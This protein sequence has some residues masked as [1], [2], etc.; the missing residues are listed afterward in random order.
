MMPIGNMVVA[1]SR[2]PRGESG[3]DRLGDDR[4]LGLF[5][6]KGSSAAFEALVKRHGPRVLGV[7]RQILR[8]HHDAEDAFQATFLLLA[9]KAGTIRKGDSVGHWLHGVAHRLAVRSKAGASRR[10]EIE[11]SARGLAM[12]TGRPDDDV[13]RREVRRVV[14]EEIDRLPEKLRRAILLC[15]V[16]GMSN[17]AAAQLLGCPSSTL[18]ERLARA[19]EALHGRLARRGLALT[20]AILLLLLLERDAT[21]EEVSPRLIRLTVDAATASGRRRGPGST[22]SS[23]GSSRMLPLIAL[24]MISATPAV[25]G[26]FYLGS[27]HR[28]GFFAWF[29]GAVREVCH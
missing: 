1:T 22:G 23:G 3:L 7:C 4:L 13:D 18:K 19:R 6:S 16:E 10:V 5:V 27:P 2:E 24:A 12:T 21:A 11:R 15:Y 8:S 29:V 26:A 25:L 28:V 20:L 9:R 14:H 17:E